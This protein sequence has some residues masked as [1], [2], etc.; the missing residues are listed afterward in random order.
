[1]KKT[2]ILIGLAA[3]LAVISASAGNSHGQT[4]LEENE[5]LSRLIGNWVSTTDDGQTLTATYRWRLNK[6]VIISRFDMAGRYA[7][8]GLAYFDPAK[9]KILHAGVDSLG[10]LGR[11]HWQ[12]NDDSAIWKL[13]YIGPDSQERKM[14]I[15][16]TRDGRKALKTE[17]YDLDDSGEL[18]GEPRMT[19]QYDRKPRK[20]AK[21]D[22]AKKRQSPDSSQPTALADLVEMGEFGWIIGNWAGTTDEGQSFT[23]SYRWGMNKNL[24]N[25]SFKFGEQEGLG[26]IFYEPQEGKVMQIGVDSQGSVVNGFWDAD[27]DNLVATLDYVALDG[28]KGKIAIVNTKIDRKTIK[29]AFHG[30][31]DSGQRSAEAWATVDYKRQAK[32][33]TQAPGTK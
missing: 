30:V 10:G 14:G 1:M 33:K 6:N 29:V 13:N 3:L 18:V 2:R 7:G 12:I 19:T 16:Y 4:K 25:M 8:Y 21:K 28:N 27:G 26:L 23:F 24:I 5:G 20:P 9:N 22:E 17:Y 15:V 11:G 32:K 31:D